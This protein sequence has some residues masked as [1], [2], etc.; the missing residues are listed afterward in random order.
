MKHVFFFF[1][2]FFFISEEI[3]DGKSS[4]SLKIDP[5]KIFTISFPNSASPRVAVAVA[6]AVVLPLFAPLH[7]IETEVTTASVNT[8]PETSADRTAS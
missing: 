5:R 3:F 6:A 1:F 8:R 7:P 2:F 4:T